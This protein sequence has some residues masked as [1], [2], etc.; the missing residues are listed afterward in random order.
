MAPEDI[1]LSALEHRL[2][3]AERR[4]RAFLLAALTWLGIQVLPQDPEPQVNDVLRAERIEV[5]NDEGR[6]VLILDSNQHGGR[7]LVKNH[8]GLRRLAGM[9]AADH[10]GF[11]WVADS[12]QIGGMLAA[13][14]SVDHEGMGSLSVGRDGTTTASL[15]MYEERG[16]LS[17]R[18]SNEKEGVALDMMVSADGG[19]V[20][21]WDVKG[22]NLFDLYGES[23][24]GR[25]DIGLEGQLNIRDKRNKPLV[26]VGC[27]PDGG[28][29]NLRGNDKSL[30][31]WSR[32]AT[33]A[34]ACSAP[35]TTRAPRSW[36][37]PPSG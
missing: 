37:S 17:L 5:V 11:V 30:G 33:G 20:A 2:R 23:G 26:S 32:P 27:G 4:N 35:A 29:F 21:G 18:S 24:H 14:M 31:S 36:S 6:A 19:R 34:R 12:T 15:G 8:G 10:G 7:L 13:Q 25:V 28:I 22:Q 1:R 9:Q 3:R 16:Y